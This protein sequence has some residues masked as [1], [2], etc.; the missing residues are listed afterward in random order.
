MQHEWMEKGDA[1]LVPIAEAVAILVLRTERGRLRIIHAMLHRRQRPQICEYRLQIII[2]EVA[3]ERIRNGAVERARTHTASAN[4]PDKLRL[5]VIANCRGIAR[6]VGAG[7][8]AP[9]ADEDSAPGEQHVRN[10]VTL[11]IGGG[12]A[13]GAGADVH[14]VFAA[15]CSR[16][17]IGWQRGRLHIGS[18]IDDW[19]RRQVALR[20]A[21][22]R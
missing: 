9:R 6:E 4:G 17:C 1:G 20:C 8:G 14:Q 11:R 5:V 10:H 22:I 21:G 3:V 12:V 19:L 15:A 18:P 2:A 16:R 13:P 7:D